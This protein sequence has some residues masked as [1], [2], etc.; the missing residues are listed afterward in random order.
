MGKQKAKMRLV[1]IK[2]EYPQAPL[3]RSQM[4]ECSGGSRT[5]YNCWTLNVSRAAG[6]GLCPPAHIPNEH[7]PTAGPEERKSKW[8]L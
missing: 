8:F 5:F 2:M 3:L 7:S 6:E 1:F 4:V